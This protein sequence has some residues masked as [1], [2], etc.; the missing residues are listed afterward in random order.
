MSTTLKTLILILFIAIGNTLLAQKFTLSGSVKDA[1]TGEELLGATILVKELSATGT[2]TNMYGFYSL[3]LP[4]GEYTIIA[5]YI[6]YE[7][8]SFKVNLNQNIKKDIKLSQSSKQLKEVVIVDEKKDENITKTQMG[9]EKISVK[10]IE[11]I[12]VLMGE[13]DVLKTIQLTPGVKSAGEG[14]TGFFVRGGGADQNLILL[15]EAVVYNASHLLGFFSVFNSDALKDVT[16]YKG[17]QPAE[18]GGRLASVLDVRM[19][20]GNDR[21]YHVDGGIG[22]IS[23]RLNVEGPIVKEKSSFAVSGR[24][25]YADLF[26][27][28]S[29]DTN[30][31]RS[32]LYFYD[33]NLKANYRISEKDRIFVSGYFGRDV[34]GLGKSFGFDWGN[35]TG[36]LRWNRIINEKLF[37]NTSFIASNYKYNINILLGGVEGKIVS[38]IRNYS[39]KQ[40]FQYYHSTKSSFK[41]GFQSIYYNIIPGNISFT[42]NNSV[43]VER[44]LNKR[45]GVENAAYISHTYKPSTLTSFEYGLRISSYSVIGPGDFYSYNNQ[46]EILDTI[47]FPSGKIAKNY[48]NPEPRVAVNFILNERS[49]IK[50]ALTRNTQN[51]HLLSNSNSGNPTDMWLANTNNIKP[52]IG[53]QVSLG[54]FRN[55]RDNSI[56]FSVESYYKYMQNQID[57]RD[58][59][60]VTLNDNVESQLL[61]GTG[62]AYGVEFLIKKKYGKL[63]G[64][65]GYTLSRVERKIEGINNGKYYP[66]RQDRT[67]DISIVT[68]YEISPKW[69]ASATWVYYTGNA[70]TF[71]SGKYE[72]AGQ[73]INYYTER[74]GYRMPDY[75]RLDI[76]LTWQRKKTE[77]FESNWNFSVYN[78]YNRE[79][80][81][82]ITFEQDP[83]DPSRTRA[84]Q[85]TLFKIVPSISYNFKF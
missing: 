27:K 64:W 21:S 74:N 16:L 54:Y 85:T 12:P 37:S 82:A 28:L 6:G 80:A 4:V 9:V 18:Y 50:T 70:V 57:Y 46:G 3:T 31:R 58:G 47:S 2:T 71:P 76:G 49:S 40:D 36:T 5:Q 77:K 48:I 33:L 23:S 67:H 66:A 14:S 84:V 19:K 25:T 69:T 45:Y 81:F 63:N 13:R 10:D 59:A 11:A 35:A 73:V 41:F 75:H 17:S 26:L 34:L 38:E 83:D 60:D 1:N 79:N 44:E 29:N 20:D 65:I 52:E 42:F 22:L 32:I 68:I 8:Q 43:G 62:R 56:E 15:D 53:D 78:A 7:T 61:Y 30:L 51:I 39:L 72:I 24:R 55:F